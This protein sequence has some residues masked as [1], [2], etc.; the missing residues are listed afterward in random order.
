VHVDVMVLHQV[1]FHRPAAVGEA[2]VLPT[3]VLVTVVA[4]RQVRVA[5][6][7]DVDPV[8]IQQVP[9][10]GTVRIQTAMAIFTE[11]HDGFPL[12]ATWFLAGLIRFRF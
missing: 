3:Q 11:S 9:F 7:S 1:L 12:T 2:H 4:V 8:S 6:Q 5:S 10:N